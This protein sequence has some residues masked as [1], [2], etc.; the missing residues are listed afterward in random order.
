MNADAWYLWLAI[1]A[2]TLATFLTRSSLHLIGSQLRLPPQLE[3]ALRYAPACALTA[4]IVPDLFLS[5]GVLD[6]S[7]GNTRLLAGVAGVAIFA[8]SRSTIGTIAGGML[9]FWLLRWLY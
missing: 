2:I 9:A 7:L 1:A 3:V 5:Q 6:L 8:A 4:I